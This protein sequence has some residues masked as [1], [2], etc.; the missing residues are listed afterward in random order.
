[1]QGQAGD[2]KLLL[3]SVGPVVCCADSYAIHRI[4]DPP[5]QLVHLPGRTYQ[6]SIFRHEGSLVSVLDVRSLFGLDPEAKRQ[7][8][9]KLII[10]EIEAGF[11]GFWVDE[12]QSII[13][14][15]DGKWGMLPGVVP[16][17]LFD[18][19]FHYQ[20]QLVLHID[21][22]KLLHAEATSWVN[23]S[24]LY[25][26]EE[27]P[28]VE[29]ESVISEGIEE[30]EKSVEKQSE[31][32]SEKPP[33]PVSE[34][35]T[36]KPVQQPAKPKSVPTIRPVD[37]KPV[38]LTA[39]IPKPEPRTKRETAQTVAP[40][41]ASRGRA[42][43]SSAAE[44]QSEPASNHHQD[45]APRVSAILVLGWFIF[46]SILLGL[47]LY[48]LWPAPGRLQAERSV[49]QPPVIDPEAPAYAGTFPQPKTSLTEAEV[50]L[51]VPREDQ[52]PES[53]EKEI[54]TVQPSAPL[55]GS[56]QPEEV[57]SVVD[58][59]EHSSGPHAT[60]E[61]QGNTVTITL[62]EAL[63]QKAAD[64]SH[65]L[66]VQSVS[67]SKNGDPLPRPEQTSMEV[68]TVAAPAVMQEERGQ[69][70][71]ETSFET[72]AGPVTTEPPRIP[73][74]A[75]SEEIIHIVVKGDTLWDIASRYIH[76]PY[77]YPELARLSNI[78]NP[79]LIYP[80]DRVRILI[81]RY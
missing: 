8:A 1:M 4:I 19:A 72:A 56:L 45:S 17:T 42:S 2:R 51:S 73:P 50:P 22:S 31:V 68:S 46:A 55:T 69:T 34:T 6:P 5:A 18:A 37:R 10:A 32:T 52:E 58:E 64:V 12:V 11:Y 35:D 30:K 41:P 43:L 39:S 61:R 81:I 60:I 67:D 44:Y 23:S 36:Q 25:S 53:G 66:P 40:E 24:G 47:L 49:G 79:D 15:K 14:A 38:T 77:R 13:S 16:R 80:G 76:D 48:V 54:N 74:H 71:S 7:Q 26:V 9:E 70:T 20:S 62:R 29:Q 63:A 78:K 65:P 27:E 75:S 59:E 28:L 21:F 3:F 57:P 33:S